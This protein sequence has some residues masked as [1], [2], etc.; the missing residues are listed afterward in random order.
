MGKESLLLLLKSGEEF[1]K[2]H[3]RNFKA[4]QLVSRKPVEMAHLCN[5]LFTHLSL[6]ELLN[7]TNIFFSIKKK[8]LIGEKYP[9]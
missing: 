6:Q 4:L 2:G 9:L 8:D 5:D 3:F 1:F 7:L